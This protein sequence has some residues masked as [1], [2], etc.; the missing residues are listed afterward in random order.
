[1]AGVDGDDDVALATRHR[2]QL[3]RRG[4]G[5]GDHRRRIGGDARRAAGRRR[6]RHAGRGAG[7]LVKQVDHQAVTILLIGC[8]AEAFRHYSGGQ[9]K[10]QT[11]IGGRALGRTN[12][13]DRRVA[14]RQLLQLG[15]QL[16]AV[17]V[18]NDAI[19]RGQREHAVLHRAGQVEDQACVVRGTP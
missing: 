9:V 5:C 2:R 18:D 10:D 4:A 13:G 19:G 11:Q 14:Q 1:M 6:L 7:F 8:Q 16:G 15:G 12:T 3:G 17:D